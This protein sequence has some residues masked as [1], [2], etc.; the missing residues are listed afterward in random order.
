M[1][2]APGFEAFI[3]IVSTITVLLRDEI[4]GFI[5]LQVVSLNPRRGVIGNLSESKYSFIREEW[6]NPLIISDLIGWLSD[7]GNEVIA[8][9]I[10]GANKSNRYFAD[11]ISV[12]NQEPLPRVTATHGEESFSYRYIG[13]SL[14]GVHLLRTWS[15]GG[16]TGVFGS[17]IL[18][19][20]S[21][22]MSLYI[23]PD[24]AKRSRRLVLKK[25]ASLALGDRYTGKIFYKW[26]ILSIGPCLGMK[27]LRTSRQSFL[28]L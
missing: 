8:I 7:S 10:V 24:G 15:S 4:H 18:V 2:T 14:S 20:L 27:T 21:E 1:Y 16:G 6:I 22:D 11:N 5:G 13:R 9:D 3:G 12:D 23:A 19:T 28:V 26:G 17:I 25:I